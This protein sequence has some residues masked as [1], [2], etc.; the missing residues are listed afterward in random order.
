[1]EGAFYIEVEKG[2]NFLGG[3]AGCGT[4]GMGGCL[5]GGGGG[6]IYFSGRKFPPRKIVE[7]E[8]QFE[9][10]LALRF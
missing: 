10:F 8:Q 1:M 6:S 3:E 5:L 7:P 2:G 4:H 9:Q